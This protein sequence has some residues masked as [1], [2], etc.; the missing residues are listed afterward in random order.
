MRAARVETLRRWLFAAVTSFAASCGTDVV[1]L[2]SHVTT[3]A[4]KPECVSIPLSDGTLCAYCGADYSEQRG[5]LKC[6]PPADSSTCGS[7]VWS[8]MPDQLCKRCI[9]ADGT[10]PT[11]GCTELRSDLKIPGT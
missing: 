1:R 5:C 9:E 10:M 3:P 2:D 8:D 7:C 6:N 11:I 4:P